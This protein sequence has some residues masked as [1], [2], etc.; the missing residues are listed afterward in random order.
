MELDLLFLQK[1]IFYNFIY[2]NYTV[3]QKSEEVLLI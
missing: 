1:C 3:V 2:Y